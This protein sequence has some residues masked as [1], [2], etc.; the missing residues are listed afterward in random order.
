MRVVHIY[1]ASLQGYLHSFISSVPF[2]GAGT[3]WLIWRYESDSTLA[4]ALAGNVGVFPECLA[5]Y[6]LRGNG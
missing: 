6:I 5:P 2:A 4:D 3:Q 1:D